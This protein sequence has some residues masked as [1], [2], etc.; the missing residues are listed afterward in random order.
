LEN[1][2]D[3][4]QAINEADDPWWKSAGKT[5]GEKVSTTTKP[6]LATARDF[7]GKKVGLHTTADNMAAKAQ[8][9]AQGLQRGVQQG[10]Q[11]FADKASSTD[12][13]L[14]AGKRLA[15]DLGKGIGRAGEGAS[16]LMRRG[17]SA[18]RQAAQ[19]NPGGLGVAAAGAGLG[20]LALSKLLRRRQSN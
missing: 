14:A 3:S 17:S 8:G 4:K 19:D 6:M 9:M 15:G 13:H 20:A 10:Y 11:K 2:G 1:R 18:I 12:I 16:D 5:V 7:W